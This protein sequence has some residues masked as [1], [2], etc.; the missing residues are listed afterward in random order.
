MSANQELQNETFL[1]TGGF[2][3]G[4]FRLFY[5]CKMFHLCHNAWTIKSIVLI[6]HVYIRCDKAFPIVPKVWPGDI[7]RDL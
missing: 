2:E 7:D 6:F 1:F 3:H 5:S 4:I